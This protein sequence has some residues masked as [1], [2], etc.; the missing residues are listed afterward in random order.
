MFKNMPRPQMGAS[1]ASSVPETFEETVL[2]VASGDPRF[3]IQTAKQNNE[4]C[5][6]FTS[7]VVQL[8]IFFEF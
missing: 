7:N 2:T 5:P 3:K 1:F 8:I 4:N 6:N